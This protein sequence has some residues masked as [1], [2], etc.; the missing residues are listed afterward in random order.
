MTVESNPRAT[1]ATADVADKGSRV[2]RGSLGCSMTAAAAFFPLLKDEAFEPGDTL[3]TAVTPC[4][5]ISCKCL[6]VV[7]GDCSRLECRFEMIFQTFLL[8][9]LSPLS[10]A[11]FTVEDHPR[12]SVGGHANHMSQPSEMSA[13][14]HRLNC[15]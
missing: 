7:E 14:Q 1:P 10:I 9:S 6:N 4:G 3:L 5:S 2:L 13:G 15:A 12:N 8:A 11:K